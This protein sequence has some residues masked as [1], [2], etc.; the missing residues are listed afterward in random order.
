MEL[1]LDNLEEISLWAIRLKIFGFKNYFITLCKKFSSREFISRQRKEFDKCFP[2]FK[3][4]CEKGI[5]TNFYCNHETDKTKHVIKYQGRSN[6]NIYSCNKFM[7]LCCSSKK[8]ERKDEHIRQDSNVSLC[9]Y[10]KGVGMY[11]ITDNFF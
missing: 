4:L 6:F 3:M 1:S 8:F 7:Y 5:H 10:D 9:I 11:L 2:E